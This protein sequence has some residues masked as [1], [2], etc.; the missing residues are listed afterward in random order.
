MTVL[1]G[2]QWG[3]WCESSVSRLRSLPIAVATKPN[4]FKEM[5]GN[6]AAAFVSTKP[7][8]LSKYM[9]FFECFLCLNLT[10]TKA[11]HCQNIK[12]EI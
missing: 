11:Q 1:S 4:I 5:L 3:W 2:G 10:R 8:V 7:G 6:F 12:I 9:F